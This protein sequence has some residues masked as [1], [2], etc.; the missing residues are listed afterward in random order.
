M[1]RPEVISRTG[2]PLT[3]TGSSDRIEAPTAAIEALSER[4]LVTTGGLGTGKTTLAVPPLLDLVD[5]P[6][7]PPKGPVSVLG[8]EI[9]DPIGGAWPNP[10]AILDKGSTMR[11]MLTIVMATVLAALA[12][13]TATTPVAY[14]K[15][16]DAVVSGDVM[17]VRGDTG[18]GHVT[19]TASGSPN[20]ASGFYTFTYTG[21][22]TFTG[23]VTCLYSELNRA[24]LTGP[25]TGSTSDEA[26]VL[27]IQDN[28]PDAFDAAISSTDTAR[29]C[30]TNFALNRFDELPA[31]DY[32]VLTSGDIVIGT[33]SSLPRVPEKTTK[34]PSQEVPGVEP[35]LAPPEPE[36]PG[37]SSQLEPTPEVPGVSPPL[38]PP[39][40]PVPAPSG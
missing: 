27:W 1:D 31:T 16:D 19:F 30:Q 10:T 12:Y 34:K 26:F 25:I 4:L 18:T 40:P 37:V 32:Y 8:S 17:G 9:V 3:F 14:A 38:T 36:I 5:D 15:A 13:S 6:G 35:P 24:V 33:M 20:Q 23:R 29:Q 2:G 7:E 28:R 39:P 11:R 22:A 21:G